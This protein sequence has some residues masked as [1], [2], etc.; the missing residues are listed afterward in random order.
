[1]IFFPIAED[2]NGSHLRTDRCSCVESGVVSEA[3]IAAKPVNDI[4]QKTVG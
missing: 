3:E 2:V 4:F 1:M